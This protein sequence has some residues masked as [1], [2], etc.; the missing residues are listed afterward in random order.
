MPKQFRDIIVIAVM[1]I[2]NRRLGESVMQRQVLAA[3]AICCFIGGTSG[4]NAAG[5]DQMPCGDILTIAE[6]TLQNPVFGAP[7][8]KLAP[9]TLG[10]LVQE[11]P[12]DRFAADRFPPPRLIFPDGTQKPKPNGAY[13]VVRVLKVQRLTSEQA[14]KAYA[15]DV[16]SDSS[17][18]MS[19]TPVVREASSLVDSRL[20][21][22]HRRLKE[23]DR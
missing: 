21:F 11:L 23:W 22:N 4:A 9:F 20:L 15:K 16:A 7:L 17:K 1:R 19:S 14:L 5:Q 10:N 12:D 6:K 13:T 18:V 8:G 2:G 3:V